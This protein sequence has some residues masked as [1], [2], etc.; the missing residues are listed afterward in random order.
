MEEEVNVQEVSS[1]TEQSAGK[2]FV[3]N[4]V[5]SYRLITTFNAQLTKFT[6]L[7]LG[8]IIGWLINQVW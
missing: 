6:Y 5:E 7:F 2:G 4:E 8:L 1:G 3:E